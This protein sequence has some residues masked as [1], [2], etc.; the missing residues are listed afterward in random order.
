MGV[1]FRLKMFFAPR[2]Q[3]ASSNS[4]ASGAG[5]SSIVSGQDNTFLLHTRDAEDNP[6]STATSSLLSG[7]LSSEPPVM[8]SFAYLS[9]GNYTATVNPVAS[10][11]FQMH[12]LVNGP[13][14]ESSPLNFKGFNE[15]RRALHKGHYM[16]KEG[17]LSN[18]S[19]LKSFLVLFK[20]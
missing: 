10:G 19:V 5:L 14:A 1:S 17:I 18:L 6:R 12:V 20:A 8:L 11:A 9:G 2:P 4:T 7:Y 3:E 13:G 15:E 16:N